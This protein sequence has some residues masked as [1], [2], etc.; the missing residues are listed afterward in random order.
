MKC[1]FSSMKSDTIRADE[2][3]SVVSS[4]ST[5]W[6]VGWSPATIKGL[7]QTVSNERSCLCG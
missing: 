4:Q 6:G 5:I 3:V 2:L 1:S 7:L